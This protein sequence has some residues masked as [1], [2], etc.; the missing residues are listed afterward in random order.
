M[1]LNTVVS[2]TLKVMGT[3]LEISAQWPPTCCQSHYGAGTCVALPPES[4]MM[5]SWGPD[6]D[7]TYIRG[8]G[9]YLGIAW[10]YEACY[11]LPSML[12]LSYSIFLCSGSRTGFGLSR[13]TGSRTVY[14]LA[15]YYYWHRLT[16][17]TLLYRRFINQFL[18]LID[19]RLFIGVLPVFVLNILYEFK[20]TPK[21]KKN[22]T[23]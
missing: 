13:L 4:I 17:R 19:W 6:V 23:F 12:E 8:W 3:V 1:I 9:T 15:F 7:G 21:R 10:H 2:P 11:T 5:P 18:Y 22:A 14:Y 20:Y 16:H